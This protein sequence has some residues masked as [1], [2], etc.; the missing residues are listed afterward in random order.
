MASNERAL[1]DEEWDVKYL[2]SILYHYRKS[3]VAVTIVA[4]LIAAWSAYFR[5]SVYTARA[6]LKITSQQQGYYEDFLYITPNGHTYDIDD[7]LVVITSKPIIQD[8]V[9]RLELGTRYFT[10]KHWKEKELY[11]AAPFRV[12]YDKIDPRLYGKPFEVQP[13]DDKRYRLILRDRSGILSRIKRIF[14]DRNDSFP[15][16]YDKTHAF[17]EKVETPFFSFVLRKHGKFTE[18]S[19]FFTIVPDESMSA[20]VRGALSA[21]KFSK[22]S[23]IVKLRVADYVPK[24]AALIANAVA[25]AYIRYT[26]K[27]KNQSAKKQLHFIDMQLEAINK[28][29]RSSAEKLQKYKAMNVV[30]DLSAKSKQLSDQLAELESTIYKKESLSN[31]IETVLSKLRDSKKGLHTYDI[32][33]PFTDIPGIEAIASQLRTV[34]ERYETLSVNYT[35]NYPGIKKLLRQITFLKHSLRR[36]LEEKKAQL[37]AETKHLRKQIERL[38]EAL[39][40]IPEQEQEIEALSRHFLVNEKIYSYLLEKRAETAIL[41]SSTISDAKVVEKASP[42]SVP[43]SPKRDVIVL[44]GAILGFIVAL[45]QAFVRDMLDTKIHTPGQVEELTTIPVYGRLPFKTEKYSGIYR[46]AMRTLW[47][48]LSFITPKRHAKIITLTSDISQEGKTFTAANLARTIAS[49]TEKQVLLIDMDMRKP[50]LHKLFEEASREKGISTLLSGVTSIEETIRPLSDI[51]NLHIIPG[52]PKAPNPTKLIMSSAFERLLHT[53]NERYDY[54][55][56]DTSPIG[57]VADALKI[58]EYSDITLFIVRMEL[59]KKEYLKRLEALK[60]RT[61]Y[62][63]G[64]V[65]NGITDKR[66]Y[67]YDDYVYKNYYD[68][69]N[70]DTAE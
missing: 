34:L 44:I 55:L 62:E 40:A 11:E 42:P 29:L 24:R 23:R 48:N 59:S 18:P 45:I 6:L 39:R 27:L 14:S 13:I 20:Y 3:I 68:D 53:L 4:T 38:R 33:I 25:D 7:E 12:R 67:H 30:I 32:D 61:D 31:R 8:A 64:L 22:N 26:L 51:P 70:E 15:F 21:A 16:R 47:I 41:A 2:F 28:K 43:T 52:G 35:E 1:S 36:A 10:I 65:L 46:E 57:L 19:Y 63:I 9:D 69:T 56:I 54:I 60:S 5:P 17:G 37:A 58:M 49:T 50:S 66:S